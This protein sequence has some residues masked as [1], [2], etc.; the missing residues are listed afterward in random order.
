[1]ATTE[2]MYRA[3]AV[4]L[5]TDCATNAS[6]NLQVYRG[7]PMSIFPPTGFVDSMSDETPPFP[8]TSSL[9]QHNRLI[10]VV[11]IWG[12]FDS[13]EA[14]DQRDAFVQAFHDWT[15]ARVHSASA[16][17]LIGPRSLSDVPSFL[18]DWG[19]EAQRETTYFATRI[20]L[21]GFA[22]D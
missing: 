8:G 10:E 4:T 13:G 18:P 2:A 16:E 9:Y 3:A 20:L 22:T 14:V 6:V 11:L 5:L 7:R 17:S 21:E 15:R 1:M 19:S 12:L